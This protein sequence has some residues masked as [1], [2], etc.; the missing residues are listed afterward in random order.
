MILAGGVGNATHPGHPKARHHTVD[1]MKAIQLD[2][3]SYLFRDLNTTVHNIC[4]QPA[5]N[6]QVC[7]IIK[8][9]D[10]VAAVGSPAATVFQKLYLELMMLPRT[11]LGEDFKFW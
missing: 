8:G 7:G 1:T 3:K 2:Y 6:Q 4:E 9:W 10:G 5:A 11:E